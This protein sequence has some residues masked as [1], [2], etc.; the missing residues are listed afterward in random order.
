M[1]DYFNKARELGNMILESDE[2]IKMLK[3]RSDF[4]ENGEAVDKTQKYNEYQAKIQEAVRTRTISDEDLKV[5]SK[6]LTEMMEDLRK[7]SV[8]NELIEAET[9]FAELTNN[10]MNILRATISGE[11][12]SE[13]GCSGCESSSCG[14]GCSC[15]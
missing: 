2:G 7:D 8:I 10:V 6:K 12:L 4:Y 13:S 1:N 11:D 5:E 9:K 14:G 15:G 3:A